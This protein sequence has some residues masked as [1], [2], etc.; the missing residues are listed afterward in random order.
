MTLASESDESC[1]DIMLEGAIPLL[2]TLL[3]SGTDMQ[4]QEAA[5]ALGKL[6]ANNEVSRGK[7]ARKG[8]ISPMVVF[9]RAVTDAQTTGP[10][11]LWVSS[12]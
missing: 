11:A 5:Y 7:T 2:V 8:A 3:R 9:V 10:C 4:K 6:A 1:E 12:L